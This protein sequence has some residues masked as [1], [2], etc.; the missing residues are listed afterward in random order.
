MTGTWW[1][2]AFVAAV[3][4]LDHRKKKLVFGEVG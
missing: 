3:F 2:C 1:P 4:A